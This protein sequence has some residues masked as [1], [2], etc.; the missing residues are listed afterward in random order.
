MSKRLRDSHG[1]HGVATKRARTTGNEICFLLDLPSDMFLVEISARLDRGSRC[2]LA[3]T[4]RPLRALLLP[5]IPKKGLKYKAVL[6][7][8]HP[9]FIKPR[10]EQV[11]SLGASA[12]KYYATNPHHESLESI[13]RLLP[14]LAR[15]IEPTY[16]PRTKRL[17][18]QV[19]LGLAEAARDD[20]IRTW[21]K[22]GQ[23]VS[24]ACPVISF[25]RFDKRTHGS[26]WTVDMFLALLARDDYLDVFEKHDLF[27]SVTG[28]LF[29]Y[30]DFEDIF[31][32]VAFK[33]RM[34]SRLLTLVQTSTKFSQTC[35]RYFK[36]HSLA[37]TSYY[38]TVFAWQAHQLLALP[39]VASA[40]KCVREELTENIHDLV[41]Y[42]GWP[43]GIKTLRKKLSC[44]TDDMVDSRELA[45]AFLATTCTIPRFTAKWTV[46]D[47]MGRIDA[48]YFSSGLQLCR[49][50]ANRSHADILFLLAW[51]QQRPE[52][53]ARQKMAAFIQTVLDYQC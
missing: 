22:S 51:A 7:E 26:V 12:A 13:L 21:R 24:V 31:N 34:V 3:A 27:P 23:T 16:G 6:A 9:R 14:S 36:V 40:E 5:V 33:S 44:L 17:A 49:L 37:Q 43:R 20:F 29:N 4:C 25:H 45:D 47:E 35:R 48:A 52:D 39:R 19:L 41:K 30:D 32:H 15:M 11:N 46:F 38:G 28:L 1:S 50:L 10:R 42:N 8:C 2:L 53:A 18:A